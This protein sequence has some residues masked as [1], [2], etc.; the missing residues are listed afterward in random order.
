MVR[1]TT[2]KANILLMLVCVLSVC[3]CF[4]PLL[5][6]GFSNKN[7]TISSY[8]FKDY[9]KSDLNIAIKQVFKNYPEYYIKNDSTDGYF[10]HY[11]KNLKDPFISQINSD[12]ICFHFKLKY[13]DSTTV[14]YWAQISFYN[15]EDWKSKESMIETE[16]SILGISENYKGW[17]GD[18]YLPK[19][20]RKESK[21][22]KKYISAFENTILPKI[23]NYIS[24]KTTSSLPKQ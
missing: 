5:F 17:K 13:N 23:R 11:G 24:T 12:S 8:Q 22:I 4:S 3:G 9:S 15:N 21:K 7:K 18:A 20:T 2:S 1:Q 14:L 16:L 10:L 6:G 19:I